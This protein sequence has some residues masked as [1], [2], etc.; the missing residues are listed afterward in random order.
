MVMPDRPVS[1]PIPCRAT[2]CGL[3]AAL[4]TTERVPSRGP[5]AVGVKLTEI[6]QAA[7]DANVAGGVGQ[8]V[9]KAKSPEVV[10]EVI[11]S[12]VV[13][14]LTLTLCAGAVL[15]TT[16][17]PNDIVVVDIPTGTT[18]VPLRLTDCGLLL[19]SSVTDNVPVRLPV[20]IGVKVTV[21][22]QLVFGPSEAGARGQLLVC[23]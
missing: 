11:V 5:S 10:I 21:I 20:V 19:A 6:V 18:P 1:D 8:V 2:V 13:L 9:E 17:F 16:R 7:P 15:F 4:S 22:T 12:G 3:V 14:F 23:A